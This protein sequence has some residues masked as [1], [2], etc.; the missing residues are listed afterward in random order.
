MSADTRV[1]VAGFHH[2]ATGSVVYVCIDPATRECAVIDAV[3]DYDVDA[4]RVSTESADALMTWINERDLKV[5]W[6]LDTHPHADHLSAAWYLQQHFDAPRAIGEKVV[7]V[8][9]IWRDLYHW[10]VG[11]PDGA[12]YWDR[13]F[14]DG[15]TFM[16]G[17][18]EARAML[19]P[20]H[21]AASITYIVGDAAFVHDTLFM[22]DAGTARADFP[23]ADARELF[24]SIEAILALPVDTRLFTGHDYPPESRGPRWEAT[25][26][27]HRAQ[28]V[29][30]KDTDAD[31]FVAERQARD[32]ELGVPDAMLA[33]LQINL[34]GGR[35]PDLEADGQAYLKIPLNRF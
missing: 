6:L 12:D 34:R 4:A 26:A 8:Q 2:E 30:L 5:V 10:P 19:S 16:I 1:E 13:T 29:D 11:F 24:H 23:G 21:T 17:K 7:E 20:G 31:G 33:A 27:E 18:Q 32:A 3:L 22:P 35:L 15:E 25:V 28:N 14:A 9:A